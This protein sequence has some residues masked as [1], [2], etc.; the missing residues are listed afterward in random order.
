MDIDEHSYAELEHVH[1]DLEILSVLVHIPAW[2]C[3]TPPSGSV[4]MLVEVSEVM[5]WLLCTIKTMNST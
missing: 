2:I 5:S 3:M 1:Y 4:H